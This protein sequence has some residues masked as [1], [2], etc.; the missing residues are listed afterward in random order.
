MVTFAGYAP[1]YLAKEKGFFGDLDVQL[2]RIEE[3]PSI[4]AGVVK[5]DLEAYLATP[6]IAL[7]TNTRPPGKAVWAIDESAGGDGVIVAGTIDDLIGLRGRKVAGEPGLPPYFIM[8][9][10]LHK[11]GLGLGDVQLQDMT[12]QNAATAF[13]SKAVDAA[14]I[15]EP[16][17]SQAKTQRKGSRVV[18]SSAQTPGL[19]VDLIFV[20][21]DVISSRSQDVKDLIAGW[22]KATEF[23]RRSPDEAYPIMAAAFNLSVDEFKDIAS[24]VRWLDLEENKRLYGTPQAPGPLFSNFGLVVEV[25]QRNRPGVFNAA[26]D[27]YLVRDFIPDAR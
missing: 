9:Y 24:G 1:L 18:V 23:I 11:H 14:A 2:H 22:R 4:R 6:D 27:Q 20:R 16:Y 19:I 21:E 3:I 25:L 7:D 13:V 12:T 15:Y 8:L 17:L 5:G 26:A 10:L